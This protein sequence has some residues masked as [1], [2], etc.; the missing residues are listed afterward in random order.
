MAAAPADFRAAEVQSSGGEQGLLGLAFHPQYQTNGLFY[1][2]YSDLPNGDNVIARY[3]VS[4]D[5][6]LADCHY[7]LSLLY[8]QLAKAREAI[9]HMA[10]Y[11]AMAGHRSS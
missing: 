7:N 4:S 9:R 5:P 11:R 8:E 3:H 2:N 10:R 6:N 1:V